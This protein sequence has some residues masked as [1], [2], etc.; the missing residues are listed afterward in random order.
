MN[1]IC[2]DKMMGGIKTNQGKW[3]L[4][5]GGDV[6]DRTVRKGLSGKMMIWTESLVFNVCLFIYLES[7]QAGEEQRE[8]E[9][10]NPKQ[11]PFCQCRAQ[12]GARTHKPWDHDLSRSRVWHST[13]WATQAPQALISKWGIGACK[14]LKGNCFTEREQNPIPP[15]LNFTLYF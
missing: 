13:D 5:T 11:T 8:R 1:E 6:L 14:Y 4:A 12:L 15:L 9:K 2:N 3:M 7:T 10:E